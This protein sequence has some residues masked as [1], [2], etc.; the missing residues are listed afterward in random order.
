[1]KSDRPKT[2]NEMSGV[3]SKNYF[4]IWI[5]LHQIREKFLITREVMSGPTINQPTIPLIWRRGT[6]KSRNKNIFNFF[7]NFIPRV[8][9]LL[10]KMKIFFMV[11]WSIAFSSLISSIVI[12]PLVIYSYSIIK[13]IASS[14]VMWTIVLL[15]E[16]SSIM[17]LLVTIVAFNVRLY[18]IIPSFFILRWR[19]SWWTLFS[20]LLL[21]LFDE[22]IRFSFF[23][24]LDPSSW[25]YL[26]SY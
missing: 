9:W 3:F 15:G 23:M 8:S 19:I 5:P 20:F 17:T 1:M 25:Y 26:D 13:P 18:Y 16:I 2:F 12:I 6:S 11:T 10:L 22:C 24:L 4:Q 21:I 14:V 7:P